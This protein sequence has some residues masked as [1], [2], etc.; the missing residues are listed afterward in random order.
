MKEFSWNKGGGLTNLKPYTINNK[1][2]IIH[3]F[4]LKQTAKNAVES[5]V[6][7]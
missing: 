5:V 4:L 3:T 7:T 2:C 6:T 1:A